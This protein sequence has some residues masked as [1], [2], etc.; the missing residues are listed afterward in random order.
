MI[1]YAIITKN[2]CINI[3]TILIAYTLIFMICI[4]QFRI[5]NFLKYNQFRIKIIDTK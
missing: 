3:I 2:V 1:S 4:N 5:I